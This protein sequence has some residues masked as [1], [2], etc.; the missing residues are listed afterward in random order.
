ML[1]QWGMIT[2]NPLA[3]LEGLVKSTARLP[4]RKLVLFVSSGCLLDRNNSDAFDRLRRVTSAAASAGVV[5]YS[6]DARGLV[7]STVDL[8]GDV[9]FDPSG[10][11]ERASMGELGATQDGL[12]A[13]AR[14]TGGRAFFNTN[15]L[16]SPVPTAIP[17]NYV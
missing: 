8:S 1:H 13:L 6:V 5:I 16:P 15:T 10:R 2:T 4:G 17:H 7:A 3:A 14:D 12:N 9:P 11:L